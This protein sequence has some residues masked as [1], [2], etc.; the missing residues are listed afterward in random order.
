MHPE[1]QV[2][3][4]SSPDCGKRFNIRGY[5][6]DRG[7]AC[8]DCGARLAVPGAVRPE[9]VLVEGD[10]AGD[11]SRTLDLVSPPPSGP[12]SPARFATTPPG[13]IVEEAT[14][15]LG[16]SMAIRLAGST[17]VSDGSAFG[18]YVGAV[19]LASGGMG[20]V[21]RAI[22]PELGRPVAIKVILG[23]RDRPDRIARFLREA[24]VTGQLVHPNIPPLHELSRAED[25]QL[26]FAMKWIEGRSLA[27]VLE[28]RAGRGPAELA[29]ARP[30]LLGALVK[31]CDALAYAHSRGVIHRDLKPD[32]IMIG[33]YGEVLLMDWGIAKILGTSDVAVDE[34]RV[35]ARELEAV[36]TLEGAMLG[37]PAYMSPEQVEGRR[38]EID[39]RSDV[40]GLGAVIYE[41]LTGA[42]PYVAR[43]LPQLLAMIVTGQWVAPSRRAPELGIPAELDRLV[44]KAMHPEKGKRYSNVREVREE[45]EAHLAGRPLAAVT[46]TAWQRATKWMRRNRIVAAFLAVVSVLVP[47]LGVSLAIAA[48]NADAEAAQ[49]TE[50]EG[51]RRVASEERDRAREALD[52]VLALSKSIPVGDLVRDGQR[53]GAWNGYPGDL[54]GLREWLA[55]ARR[56]DGLRA[57]HEAKIREIEAQSG[58]TE[59]DRWETE[60]RV[61]LVALLV[62]L[63]AAIA[64]AED[65]IVRGQ[66]LRA[67]AD[68]P[69]D[70]AAWDAAGRVGLALP[71]IPG[72]LPIG[73]D[74]ESRTWEFWLVESGE[75]PVRDAEARIVP[76]PEMGIVLVL[77]PGG[78]TRVGS[79]RFSDEQPVHEVAVPAF[80]I[81]KFEMTQ[82]Q[83]RRATGASPSH[84]PGDP[85]QPVEQV[86][87]EESRRTLARWGLRLPS[88]AEWEYAARAGTTSEWWTDDLAGAGNLADR[89]GKRRGLAKG[90]DWDDGE[91][92][93]CPVGR[94]RA[95]PLGLHDTIGNV[96][97]W[98]E[99]SYHGDYRGAPSDG[100]AWVEPAT[101]VRTARGG[102]YG[103]LAEHSRSA[104]R[105]GFA[106]GYRV[107]DLGVR[108]A[109][110]IPAR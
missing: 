87:W 46:Y 103:Q 100:S 90:E 59:S 10:D 75:R 62:D 43:I 5:R 61:K 24:Q 23:K 22:D 27:A 17:P 101:S 77:L 33:A 97:E 1:R 82:A 107:G 104:T 65:G 74:P 92:P 66:A 11:S 7:Y 53:L 39:E 16:R 88:E 32:N 45:I 78:T 108:P 38:E 68:D 106:P 54:A 3:I 99:D 86:S 94:Y 36:Q 73:Q 80:L 110:A 34:A 28:E 20:T 56:F 71:R 55:R 98:C 52:E 21:Y 19:E 15:A 13:T 58:S 42:Q 70:R 31:V 12:A 83:W 84:Y 102:A 4:C 35:A 85:L 25:G 48:R 40:Y 51:Q 14:R 49:R 8:K 29:A 89:T 30:E 44:Q 91:G 47:L 96:W 79:P 76:A 2:L 37:T 6:P 72:V 50:A 64:E 26:Y 81:S 105:S 93:P 60:N 95:N 57:H 69:D 109:M 9:G 67:R 41:V 18:R 63:E